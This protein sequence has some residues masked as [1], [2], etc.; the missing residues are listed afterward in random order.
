L[1]L[2]CCLLC[3]VIQL[4][5]KHSA[6]CW[7]GNLSSKRTRKCSLY[8]HSRAQPQVGIITQLSV[9]DSCTFMSW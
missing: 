4:P 1:E 5:R 6:L 2:V 7:S 3:G 9:S 8:P